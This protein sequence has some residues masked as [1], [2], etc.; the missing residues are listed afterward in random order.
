VFA[1]RRKTDANM[2]NSGSAAHGDYVFGWE[3]DSLQ[4]AMDNGC[5]LNQACPKAGLTTQTDSQYSAC[6]KKQQAPE[7]V[8]GCKS[9]PI[10]PLPNTN[11]TLICDHRA[12]GDAAG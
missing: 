5:T 11:S 3:G 6:T 8:D 9:T 4:K 2:A 1:F 10:S 7:D 12:P